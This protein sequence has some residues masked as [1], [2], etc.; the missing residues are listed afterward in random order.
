MMR[1]VDW[2]VV[3]IMLCGVL[4]NIWLLNARWFFV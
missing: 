2:Y 3:C 4:Y 1:A